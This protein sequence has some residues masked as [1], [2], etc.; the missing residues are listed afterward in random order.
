[1]APGLLVLACG[2]LAHELKA[3]VEQHALASSVVVECLPA[4]L[5]NRPS[6]I[7][8]AVAER[9]TR[10][11]E[12]HGDDVRILVG[13]ADCGTG[14]HLQALCA[15]QDV[16]M[17]DGAH[18]YEFFATSPRFAELQDAEIGSFYLT[19]FLV[20]HFDRMVWQGLGLDRHP[21]L[22][23]AYF[24]NYTRLVYLAQTDD[25]ALR[26]AAERAAQRLGLPLLVEPTSYG[27]LETTVVSIGARA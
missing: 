1:M 24:G 19:D 21:E 4:S 12:R 9:I 7:T 25:P 23:S 3:I 27:E 14:G 26:T 20:R 16:E 11:R 18:C 2:A 17:L 15:D 5:H 10:A 6:E 13:Y 8:G 22:L